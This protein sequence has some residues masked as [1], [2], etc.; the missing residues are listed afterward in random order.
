MH[1]ALAPCTS[2][3]RHVRVTSTVCPF[4]GAALDAVQPGAASCPGPRSAL[5]R[6]AFVSAHPGTGRARAA[7]TRESDRRLAASGTG[8]AA[9]WV[10]APA[11]APAATAAP[12]GGV[13]RRGG[14]GGAR[15]CRR[16]HRRCGR[17][18]RRGG[19]GGAGAEGGNIQPPYGA[20]RSRTPAR[21]A[22]S[23]RDEPSNDGA[24]CTLAGA[25][26]SRASG[27]GDQA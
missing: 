14:G 21:R 5:A 1:E 20:A 22:S 9:R 27:A 4:C 6:A 10:P 24:R 18:R 19:A 8:A 25:A 16:Q 7:A 26:R 17:C 23:R 11:G 15:R 2:C 13:R 3:R 12:A